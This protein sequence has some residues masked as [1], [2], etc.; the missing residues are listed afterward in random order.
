M[1]REQLARKY[2]K[3]GCNCAQAVYGAFADLADREPEKA[4]KEA[5]FWGGGAKVKCGAVYAAEQII[6]QYA[7]EQKK[8]ITDE[9]EKAF[10]REN[11]DLECRKLLASGNKYRK[12]CN[13]Y[14]GD[15]SSML[16]Q[17]LSD[18]GHL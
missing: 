7:G 12:T 8:Q 15:A 6:N 5:R 17:V 3:S 2:H 11:G 16:V 13:D 9:F 1:D 18:N 14:V 10:I 4:M